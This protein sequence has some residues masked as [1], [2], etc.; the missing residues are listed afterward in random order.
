[1]KVEAYKAGD[2]Q[3]GNWSWAV[4]FP[5]ANGRHSQIA[6]INSTTCWNRGLVAERV[7]T[8]MAAV[9]NEEAGHG[10]T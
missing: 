10:N 2:V 9:L 8:I 3:A 7:A 4:G 6:T 1:M 5:R